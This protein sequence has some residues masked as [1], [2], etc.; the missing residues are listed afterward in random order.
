MKT[1]IEARDSA[2]TYKTPHVLS[3]VKPLAAI[4]YSI[5]SL[6]FRRKFD[7]SLST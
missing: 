6:F 5:S 3:E 4:F 1:K 7:Q 2:V